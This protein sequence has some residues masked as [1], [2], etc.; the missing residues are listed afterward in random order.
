MP[1]FGCFDL[2]Y[3]THYWI[4]I[5]INIILQPADPAPWLRPMMANRIADRE[6]GM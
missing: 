3:Q 4:S 1:R 2:L 6:I 5:Q